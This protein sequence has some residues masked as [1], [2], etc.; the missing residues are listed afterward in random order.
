[1]FAENLWIPTVATVT[2][3]GPI[4]A[5]SVASRQCTASTTA[6]TLGRSAVA[7]AP[8][9]PMVLCSSECRLCAAPISSPDRR[10][11]CTTV[12]LPLDHVR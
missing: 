3:G 9:S 11:G 12:P 4:I 1:M 5:V 7:A 8:S 6:D 10:L 2:R